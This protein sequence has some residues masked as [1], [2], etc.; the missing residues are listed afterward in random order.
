MFRP[1]SLALAA[2]CAFAFGG[3]ALAQTTVPSAA[4]QL[5]SGTTT[6]IVPPGG[7]AV[8]TAPASSG[9]QVIRGVTGVS[10]PATQGA[11]DANGLPP[12]DTASI[13]NVAGVVSYC[14]HHHLATDTTARHV[15]RTLAKRSDVKSDQGYSIGGQGLLQNGTSQPFDI[16]SLDTNK[17]T[18]LC[19]EVVKRGQTLAK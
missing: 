15:G 14:V 17:K 10:T 8:G 4:Q 12:V 13:G 2:T 5:P 1:R 6:S 7:V 19:S 18:M 11:L 16:T 3:A 9:A